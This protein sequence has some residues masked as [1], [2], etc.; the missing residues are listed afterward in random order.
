MRYVI[1]ILLFSFEL[2]AQQEEDAPYEGILTH[3]NYTETQL[4]N[5]IF[6]K[7]GCAGVENIQAIGNAKGIGYFENAEHI[8]GMNRGI[9]LSTGSVTT[10]M[11][12]NN[13][14]D[15]QGDF[16]DKKGDKDLEK[17]SSTRVNDAVGL[18]FEFVPVEKYVSFRYIFASEEYCEFVNSQFNDVFGFFVSGPG[19]NG[20]FEDNAIN[21]AVLPNTDDYVSINNINHLKNETFYVSNHLAGDDSRCGILFTPKPLWGYIEYDGFTTILNAI[22]RVVPC[23][24]YKIKLV[25]ADVGDHLYDSAV[26]LEAKS[27]SLGGEVDIYVEA[28]I[29]NTAVQEGCGESYFIFERTNPDRLINEMVLPLRISQSSTAIEGVDY[30]ALPDTLVIPAGASRFRL[31]VVTFD[32]PNQ[33][34]D[35]KLILELNFG[36][37]CLKTAAELVI[38]ELEPFEAIPVDTVIC[39]N[40]FTEIDVGLKGGSP[41]YTYTYPGQSNVLQFG[42][43]SE[44]DTTFQVRID[45][46]CGQ[47][48]S[49]MVKITT[50]EPPTAQLL[51]GGTTCEGDSLPYELLLQ[52]IPPF[53]FHQYINGI[54]SDS[55]YQVYNNTFAFQSKEEGVYTIEEFGDRA[56]PGVVSGAV[57]HQVSQIDLGT[58]IVEPAC[59]AGSNG[60][61]TLQPTGGTA[62]YFFDWEDGHQGAIR[63]A[64]SAGQYAVTV[65]DINGCMVR[66]NIGLYN[67]SAIQVAF[68]P[69]LPQDNPL[70]ISG[71]FPPYSFSEDGQNFEDE[72]IFQQLNPGDSVYL[73]ISDQNDCRATAA[74]IMPFQ[75]E[76]FSDP[77]GDFT[78]NIG[79]TLNLAPKYLIPPHLIDT[80]SWMPPEEFS[81]ANCPSPN[82]TGVQNTAYQLTITDIFGCQQI[83]EGTISVLPN[84][85][86]FIPNAFSPNAD[87]INDH[88]VFFVDKRQVQLL[89]E[90]NIFDRWG[91]RV[92]HVYR[93]PIES[94]LLVWDG[95]GQMPGL[96]LYSATLELV[97]GNRM[98]VS[99]SVQLIK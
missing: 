92:H 24:R 96:Y 5:D 55:F 61:I 52:G 4:V 93:Q 31:P 69:C 44:E 22:I 34:D 72:M 87:G 46:N 37:N 59:S 50:T 32:N 3:N 89:L 45:D 86:F 11:G 70:D 54:E 43:N 66:E 98:E 13:V 25:V 73:T 71:G 16:N 38:T 12:P 41:P 83:Q 85:T 99:G 47:S 60:T 82:F 67:Y 75:N 40:V 57:V 53:Y 95:G 23:E 6:L 20:E 7:G 64:L 48:D 51:G 8:L 1:L 65:E 10:A 26:F 74:F 76:L 81:C 42:I 27:F 21:A 84:A 29:R 56:C 88:W 91:D 15:A 39:R 14:P 17:L 68:V 62:P 33:K 19:L 30:Q 78:I 2:M 77:L 97:N 49:V 58:S 80:L 79:K 63:E 35:R 94:D 90:V 28:P 9:I 18:S 36:C